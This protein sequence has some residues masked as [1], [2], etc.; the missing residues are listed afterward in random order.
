MA[1]QKEDMEYVNN[2]IKSLDEVQGSVEEIGVI[3]RF[4]SSAKQAAKYTFDFKEIKSRLKY[5]ISNSNGGLNEWDAHLG[6]AER[7]SDLLYVKDLING[8]DKEKVVALLQR[9]I[10]NEISKKIEKEVDGLPVDV[11]LSRGYEIVEEALSQLP[12]GSEAQLSEN[13]IA[14]RELVS[15][16]SDRVFEGLYVDDLGFTVHPLRYR[17]LQSISLAQDGVDVFVDFAEC[18]KSPESLLRDGYL[19]KFENKGWSNF[20]DGELKNYSGSLFEYFLNVF[21]VYLFSLGS[22]SKE[23]HI[24]LDELRII[25][26]S[27]VKNLDSYIRRNE[28]CHTEFLDSKGIAVIPKKLSH[29]FPEPAERNE[30]IWVFFEKNKKYKAIGQRYLNMVSN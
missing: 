1:V 12:S 30:K 17:V 23:N 8:G 21:G 20:E 16:E 6:F 29:F 19:P 25:S 26:P 24:Y 4:H 14:Q 3:E 22:E 13:I 11:R 18:K 28:R 5:I 27:L 9:E 7:L 15:R 10:K 2:E